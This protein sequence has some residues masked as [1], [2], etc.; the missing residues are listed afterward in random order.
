MIYI[1]KKDTVKWQPGKKWLAVRASN[2]AYLK[3]KPAK[4]SP[5]LKKRLLFALVFIGKKTQHSQFESLKALGKSVFD[6]SSAFS[7]ES[8]LGK[9]LRELVLKD[10][11]L[12]S[13]GLNELKDRKKYREKHGEDYPK[14]HFRLKK[15]VVG[16]APYD[17][18]CT[19]YYVNAFYFYD[20]F[21]FEMYQIFYF[22]TKFRPEVEGALKKGNLLFFLFRNWLDGELKRMFAPS[23]TFEPE[24]IFYFVPEQM[25]I[26]ERFIPFLEKNKKEIAAAFPDDC[27][28]L[29]PLLGAYYSGKKQE[30]HALTKANLQSIKADFT[31][32]MTA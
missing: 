21:R 7:Q 18:R 1:Y 9:F 2:L 15:V 4:L 26:A 16:D 24:I 22:Y 5:E 25:T 13:T 11:L 20:K 10:R 17:G 23:G 32:I 19:D 28:F 14:D 29:E 12:V 27:S 31:N 30:I 3:E 6:F 8:H